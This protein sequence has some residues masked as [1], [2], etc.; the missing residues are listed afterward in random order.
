MSKA[1]SL[2]IPAKA[3]IYPIGFARY[4]N[5]TGKF[6]KTLAWSYVAP[7][8]LKAPD[9]TSKNPFGAFRISKID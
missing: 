2:V 9:V 7:R 3:G 4:G 1:V 5:S 6:R 8:A